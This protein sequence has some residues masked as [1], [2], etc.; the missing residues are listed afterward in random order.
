[1]KK[2]MLIALVGLM[3]FVILGCFG[4]EEQKETV[5]VQQCP[6]QEETEAPTIVGVWYTSSGLISFIIAPGFGSGPIEDDDLDIL[7]IDFAN[8]DVVFYPQMENSI[9]YLDQ[10]SVEVSWD[11]E[12]DIIVKACSV[13]GCEEVYV[14]GFDNTNRLELWEVITWV[15][16]S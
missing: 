9:Y 15:V 2:W 6:D 4:C 1:M 5:E 14:I 16:S 3:A 11:N 8:P 12:E 7:G 13:Y 10:V